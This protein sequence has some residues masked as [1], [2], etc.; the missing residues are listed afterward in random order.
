MN[1]KCIAEQNKMNG[2]PN[3][4]IVVYVN[5][6]EYFVCMVILELLCNINVI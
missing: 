4:F 5:F 2:L 1:K 6:A 3:N